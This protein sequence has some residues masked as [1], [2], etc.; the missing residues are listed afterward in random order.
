MHVK[1]GVSFIKIKACQ[2]TWHLDFFHHKI[3]IIS[4]NDKLKYPT[5]SSHQ[6]LQ[7]QLSCSPDPTMN[8]EIIIYTQS[9]TSG[10]VKFEIKTTIVARLM[11]P[12]MY[13]LI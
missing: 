5:I 7:R 8:S 11:L 3:K 10:W 13:F 1:L 4:I 12:D 9:F 6:I 2:N